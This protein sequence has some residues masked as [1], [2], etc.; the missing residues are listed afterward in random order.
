MKA[1]T[2]QQLERD[3]DRIFDDVVEN[4]EHYEITTTSLDEGG[5]LVE[6]AVVLIP[7]EDYSVLSETY[8]EWVDSSSEWVEEVE[9]QPIEEDANT[10]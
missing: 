1:I 10:L 9:D 5:R 3:F 7:Y 2:L 6:S 8:D 4:G